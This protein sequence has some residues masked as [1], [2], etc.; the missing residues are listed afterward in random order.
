MILKTFKF[1][2]APFLT[3]ITMLISDGLAL[4]GHR[5]NQQQDVIM[6]LVYLIVVF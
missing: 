3:E 5:Y 1:I 4:I 2:E 6:V